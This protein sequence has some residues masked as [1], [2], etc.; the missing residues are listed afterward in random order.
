[1]NTNNI[2]SLSISG[3]FSSINGGF[4]SSSG[5]IITTSGLFNPNIYNSLLIGGTNNLGFYNYEGLIDDFRVYNRVLQNYEI[6]TLFNHP[7]YSFINSNNNYILSTNTITNTVIPKPIN[8]YTSDKL[9]DSNNIVY[10]SLSGIVGNDD[11]GFNGNVYYN[12]INVGYNTIS[13]S[14]I[15]TGITQYKYFIQNYQI[16]GLIYPIQ[17][18]V[19]FNFSKNYDNNFYASVVQYT[20]SGILNTDL[21]KVDIS[22]NYIANYTTMYPTI[23]GL[24]NVTNLS[25]Y[26]LS[27]NNYYVQ[28]SNSYYGIITPRPS[29]SI[30]TPPYGYVVCLS[31]Y[32]CRYV[33]YLCMNY[34]YVN[35]I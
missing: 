18:F 26:G 33:M 8:I 20:I 29:I 7:G 2:L 12:N 3:I 31:L 35:M 22:T 32:I 27:S 6:N 5:L 17:L 23:S 11:V 19:N 30:A 25:V 10:Y 9:Y 13:L 14:G 4:L 21:G 34:I 16:F 28:S 24:V 1:L 15:L